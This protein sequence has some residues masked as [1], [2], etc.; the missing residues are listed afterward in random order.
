MHT[1]KSQWL[2]DTTITPPPR[3]RLTSTD[4]DCYKS[5]YF[6]LQGQ[7]FCGKHCGMTTQTSVKIVQHFAS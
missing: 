6:M 2:N 1:R 5:A 7:T 3:K 4:P